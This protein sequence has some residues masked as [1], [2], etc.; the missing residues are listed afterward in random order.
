MMHRLYDIDPAAQTVQYGDAIDPVSVSVSDV[1]DPA[2]TL[3]ISV[4]SGLPTGLVAAP[5]APGTLTISGNPLVQAG[6]YPIQLKVA[7]PQGAMS[8]AAVTITVN[9]ENASVAFPSTNPVAVK[10]NS[11]GGTAG[12]VTICTDITEALDASA[13]DISKAEAFF[14]F[15]AVSGGSAPTPGAVAYVGGGISGT[16]QACTTVS[17][18]R[19]DVYDV[20]VTIVGLINVSCR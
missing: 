3:T 17:N 5:G 11:A 16:L 4:V 15:S 14:S 13:G 6:S 2:S 18:V 8:T 19:V 12:P 20:A 7:D 10:V 9:A 1:D